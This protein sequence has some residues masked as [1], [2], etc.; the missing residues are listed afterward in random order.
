MKSKRRFWEMHP[1]QKPFSWVTSVSPPGWSQCT[2]GAPC[3]AW[4]YDSVTS[5]TPLLKKP[6]FKGNDTRS[7]VTFHKWL[8]LT[9]ISLAFTCFQMPHTSPF[10]HAHLTKRCRSSSGP[11]RKILALSRPCHSP[12]IQPCSFPCLNCMPYSL[13]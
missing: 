2:C 1:Q 12:Q 7:K 9:C 6:K 5:G 8:S 4:C 13:A 3:M 11:C 10:S